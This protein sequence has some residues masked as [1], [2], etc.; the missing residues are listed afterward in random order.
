MTYAIHP[1]FGTCTDLELWYGPDNCQY[2]G[3]YWTLGSYTTY[4]NVLAETVT[5]DWV[6]A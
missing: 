2:V 6:A 4:A 1:K 3:G 5:I